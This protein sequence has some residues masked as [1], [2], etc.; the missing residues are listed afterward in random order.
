[1]RHRCLSKELGALRAAPLETESTHLLLLFLSL[2]L[3]GFC[4]GFCKFLFSIERADFLCEFEWSRPGLPSSRA[5]H[6]E[7]RETSGSSIR[8]KPPR[9][10]GARVGL[11]RRRD[12]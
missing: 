8:C 9:W 12:N 2:R 11:Q 7:S 5:L 4:R 6:Y 1:M 3:A 10:R